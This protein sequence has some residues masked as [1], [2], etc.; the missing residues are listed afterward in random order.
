MDCCTFD[1][2]EKME[3]NS[4]I[5]SKIDR[6]IK[7]SRALWKRESAVRELCIISYLIADTMEFSSIIK[8][9]ATAD[10]ESSPYEEV[11]TRNTE[12][13]EYCELLIEKYSKGINSTI[14]ETCKT[15][16]WIYSW[17]F[18]DLQEWDVTNRF[19]HGIHSRSQKEIWPP[20]DDRILKIR[21]KLA[22]LQTRMVGFTR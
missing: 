6:F 21:E 16:N 7:K 17:L 10:L 14:D 18:L 4:T 1:V 3:A 9:T 22:F 20:L 8:K 19:K 12:H 5:V 15:S 13:C 2:N 11:L